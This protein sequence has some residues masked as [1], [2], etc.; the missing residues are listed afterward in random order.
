VQ[1]SFDSNN[2]TDLDRAV[3][4]VVLGAELVLE[5]ALGKVNPKD[6]PKAPAAPKAAPAKKAAA[7]PEPTPE[8]EPV[9]EPEVEA[10]DDL[11]GDGEGPVTRDDVVA[12]AS[13]LLSRGGSADLKKALNEVGARRVSEIADADL[14]RFAKLLG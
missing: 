5:P 1:L 11:M 8:P 6:E 2:L 9:D 12:M 7:K 4:A 13:A 10:E 3:L 14:G